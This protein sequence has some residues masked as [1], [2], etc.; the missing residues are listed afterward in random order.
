MNRDGRRRY[1]FTLIELVVVMSIGAVLFAIARPRLV[2][3]VENDRIRQLN[4]RVALDFALARS[5]AIKLRSPVTVRFDISGTFYELVGVTDAASP[6]GKKTT[7]RVDLDGDSNF[8]AKITNADFGGVR[9][10]S[11]DQFGRPGATGSV[12]INS[13]RSKSIVAVD[14]STGKVT[15]TF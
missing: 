9:E 4:R 14:K 10:V 6:D 1:G 3:V 13:G 8:G 15:T 11:F 5:E 7:Y 2:S 12:T